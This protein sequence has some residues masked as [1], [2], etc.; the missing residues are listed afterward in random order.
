MTDSAD[1]SM[2]RSYVA[3]SSDL[4]R[5]RPDED[6][7][8]AK[9]VKVLHG[10]NERAFKKY[11]HAIRD[12]HAKSHGVLGG[13]LTVYPDLPD[14]LRQGLFATP[15]ATYPVIARLSSTAGII[16]SDQVPGVRAIAIKVLGVHGPRALPQDQAT[17]QDFVFVNKAEFPFADAHDYSKKGML[18][19]WLLARTPDTA[20]RLTGGLMGRAA[21]VLSLVG[22]SLPSTVKLFTEPNTHILAQTFNTAAPL[23]YGDYVAKISVA[24][25]STSVK[26]LRLQQVRRDA[27]P[28]AQRDMVVDFFR[29][30]SA[31]YEVRAQLCTDPDKM[32]IEDAKVP[33]PESDSPYIRVAT[34]TFPVQNAYSPQRRAYADD[35]LSFNSW[36]SL[37]DHRPLGSINRLKNE[38]Y[39]AS[40]RF[41]H[42]KNK[43]SEI[44]P[45]DIAQLPD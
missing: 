39:K 37:A 9:I 16:R 32:P 14:H 40:S 3:Y 8:I 13:E 25:L 21:R 19:A 29:S 20:L 41:R 12:A 31:E 38:V 26:E 5:P 4:E 36:R 1:P 42:E 15:G 6:E 22:A 44:E 43:V 27:G 18:S 17:T 2:K 33:W 35:V 24:P 30:N 28:D 7:D 11:K 34:I 45:T 10:N 23:R